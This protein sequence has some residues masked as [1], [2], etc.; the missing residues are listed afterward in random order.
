MQVWLGH[1][2]TRRPSVRGWDLSPGQLDP[3]SF[4][5]LGHLCWASYSQELWQPA[6]RPLSWARPHPQ[7]A[8]IHNNSQLSQLG[9]GGP[10]PHHPLCSP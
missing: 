3:G 10:S 8:A 7:N 4:I 2:A 6:H 1:C 9:A 5:L